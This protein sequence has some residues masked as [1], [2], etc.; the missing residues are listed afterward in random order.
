LAKFLDFWEKF[1]FEIHTSAILVV[2][3]LAEVVGRE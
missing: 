2:E 1:A 3:D